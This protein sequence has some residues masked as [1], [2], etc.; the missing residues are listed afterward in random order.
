MTAQIFRRSRSYY[1]TMRNYAWDPTA[2]VQ[3]SPKQAHLLYLCL[4][5]QV[6]SSWRYF[7]LSAPE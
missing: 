2:P 6:P 4:R 3:T 7:I 5:C 1:I